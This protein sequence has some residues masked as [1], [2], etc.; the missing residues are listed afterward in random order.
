[1][2][3]LLQIVLIAVVCYQAFA[4]M[5]MKCNFNDRCDAI[6]GTCSIFPPGRDWVSKFICDRIQRCRCWVYKMDSCN[7]LCTGEEDQCSNISPGF[8]WTNTGEVCDG[9]N[10]CTCW[11]K[12]CY[13][14]S[15]KALGGICKERRPGFGWKSVSRC[16]G[17]CYC[18]KRFSIVTRPTPIVE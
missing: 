12:E 16:R 4:A 11:S 13:D 1:M 2:N 14:D 3:L 6:G 7:G 10:G 9:T 18:W 8:G 15:C 17:R 5:A